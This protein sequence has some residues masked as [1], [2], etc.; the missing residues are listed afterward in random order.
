[1][2]YIF[3]CILFLAASSAFGQEKLKFGDTGT[4]NTS[5]TYKPNNKNF[6]RKRPIEWVKNSS[7]GL[8]IGNKCMD[9]IYE[10]MGF[11]YVIQT[12]QQSRR[13]TGFERFFHNMVSKFRIML[14]NGPFWKFKLKKKRKEC[15]RLSGDYVG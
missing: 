4:T 10:E 7:A 12:K 15:R 3:L 14:K 11:V 13:L 2:R 1:M 5:P 9:N 6:K 8:L